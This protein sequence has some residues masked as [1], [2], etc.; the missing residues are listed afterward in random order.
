MYYS[1][2]RARFEMKH[3][4]RDTFATANMSY[5]PNRPDYYDRKHFEI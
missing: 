5:Q 1:L 4:M 3:E 2:P